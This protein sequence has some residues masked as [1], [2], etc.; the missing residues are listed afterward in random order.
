[1]TDTPT[2]FYFLNNSLFNAAYIEYELPK[3][4]VFK[5]DIS[6]L[7]AQ[8]KALFNADVFRQVNEA[9]LESDF[10]A[11]VLGILGWSCIYQETF[12]IQGKTNKPD[13]SLLPS[14][15]KKS[16]FY[17]K[18][19]DER[20]SLI[21]A[22]CESKEFNARLDTGK[23]DR[24]NN[25]HFQMIDYLSSLK[26][27][28][29][30]LTNGR[31]WRLYDADVTSGGKVFYEIDL[32]AIIMQD[33]CLAFRY[34]YHLF[35]KSAFIPAVS[36][37]VPIEKVREES[38]QL[39]LQVEENLKAVIYGISGEDSIFE[40]IGKCLNIAYPDATTDEIYENSMTL[41]FRLLFIA[42]FEDNNSNLLKIHKGYEL[43]ALANIYKKLEKDSKCYIGWHK[44]NNLFKILDKGS[45]TAQIPL[46]N[47]GLFDPEQ[48][49]LLRDVCIYDDISLAKILEPLFFKTENG[50]VLLNLHSRTL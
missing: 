21:T 37:I 15:E 3:E 2:D 19:E 1:M 46:F 32:E 29:G 16:D 35:K 30:F 9:T 49:P 6:E 5:E 41:L 34:F 24:Q 28:Y 22:I 23:V 45:E 36:G 7:F 47:G 18:Q 11:P 50:A 40:I 44:L 39:T 13:W 25:P 48:A 20:I 43:H 8:V 14:H 31:L 10:I 38:I 12:T 4:P 33:D 17:A 27:R 42:Y 26:V